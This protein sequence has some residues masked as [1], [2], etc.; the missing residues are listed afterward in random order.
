ME[1]RWL[2]EVEPTFNP[3]FYP[4]LVRISMAKIPV[5]GCL[6][7]RIFDGIGV[8]SW[9]GALCAWHFLVIRMVDRLDQ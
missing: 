8:D 5:S 1:I 7:P 9:G 3:S 4:S 2:G 6:N